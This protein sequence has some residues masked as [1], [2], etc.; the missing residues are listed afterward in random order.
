MAHPKKTKL[1]FL[2]VHLLK[3]E[4]SDQRQEPPSKTSMSTS[5]NTTQKLNPSIAITSKEQILSKYP[6]VFE[7]ISR[8]PG[9][10]YHIQVNLKITP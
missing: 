9:S 1:T 8:F 2:K 5:R 7:G 6:D 3:Q 4:V 10:P